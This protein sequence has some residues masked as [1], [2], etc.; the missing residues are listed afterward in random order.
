MAHQGINHEVEQTKVLQKLIVPYDKRVRP[1]AHNPTYIQISLDIKSFHSVS[2]TDMDLSV[3]LYF[4]QEWNDPRLKHNLTKPLTLT[5]SVADMIW[6]PDTFFNDA[7][8]TEV[9][10]S[11]KPNSMLRIFQEGDIFYSLLMSLTS[12]CHMDLRMFPFDVQICQTRVSS[13]AY[14]AD[15]ILVKWSPNTVKVSDEVMLPQYHLTAQQPTDGYEQLVTG[16]VSVV[17]ISFV[18]ERQLGFYLLQVYMPS[19]ALV[20][21]AWLTLWID[22]L[23]C[24]PTRASLA[25]TTM[26]ALVTQSTWLRSEIPKVAYITALDVW[27]VTCQILVFLILLQFTTV[28]YLK[29][30][31]AKKRTSQKMA[32]D[33]VE[34]ERYN[35]R[36]NSRRKV[37]ETGHTARCEENNT[38]NNSNKEYFH[39]LEQRNCPSDT[40]YEDKSIKRETELLLNLLHPYD[41]RVRPNNHGKP[42]TI[43]IGLDIVSFQSVSETD[44]DWSVMVYLRQTW[45]DPR[46]THN[47]SRPLTVI[48][49]MTDNF[50]VPDIFFMNAKTETVH[51]SPTRN[52]KILIQTNGDINYKTRMSITSSCPMDLR[53]FPFDRQECKDYLLSYSYTVDDLL[54]RWTNKNPLKIYQTISLPQYNLSHW[55]REEGYE[56]IEGNFSYVE[57]SFVLERQL[58]F[59]LLQVYIPSSAL[60]IIAWLTLWIDASTSTPAR[61]SLGITTILA[62]VTQSSWLRSEIPK[63]AYVTAL[64]VWMVTCQIVVFLIL[65]QFAVIYFLSKHSNKMFMM[66]NRLYRNNSKRRHYEN[67]LA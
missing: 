19:G 65:L 48:G 3:M 60:V 63:V 53:T 22:A 16:N 25:I 59:Y 58:G 49:Q 29:K 67:A 18:L 30:L 50:W 8:K 57:V 38:G 5:G 14:T 61:V 11:P 62:L 42:V 20:I 47:S 10:S 23:V 55:K 1:D 28:Y 6:L 26:L 64:D 24:S 35:T 56:L 39:L 43:H 27:L 37:Y 34:A 45:N 9:H 46:L 33:D 15:D 41:A 21:I 36:R 12:S 52:T 7:K 31:N 51:A 40:V 54:V 4:Q 2:E 17:K 66:N 13:Y 44:M 32:T